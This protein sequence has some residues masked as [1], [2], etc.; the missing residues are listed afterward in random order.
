[1]ARCNGCGS[2]GVNDASQ[3]RGLLKGSSG[4]SY[5]S[6]TGEI[7][8]KLSTEPGSAL[9]FGPDGGLFA[10]AVEP[11]KPQILMGGHNTTVTGDGSSTEPWVVS[12]ATN[13]EEVRAAFL[14]GPGIGFDPA[15]GFIYTAVSPLHGNRVAAHPDGLYV[16]PEDRAALVAG[17]NVTVT[18]EGTQASP[19]VVSAPAPHRTYT[20]GDD[21]TETVTLAVPADAVAVV[22][23]RNFTVTNPDPVRAVRVTGQRE[24][25][26]TLDMP[27]GTATAPSRAAGGMTVADTDTIWNNGAA[28]TGSRIFSSMNGTLSASLAPGASMTVSIPVVLGKGVGATVRRIVYDLSC[29]LTTI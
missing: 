23:T 10:P 11:P 13:V 12:A 24:L 26:L 21:F 20:F 2:G 18:G 5:N 28:Q 15:S 6:G 4:I 25:T 3:I 9:K 17:P 29:V 8:A 1:M 27:A 22:R 19:W 14:A 7:A 16:A